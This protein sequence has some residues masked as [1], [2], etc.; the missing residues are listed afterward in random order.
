[1]C[2]YIYIYHYQNP[3]ITF[4]LTGETPEEGVIKKQRETV[5]A[6]T[7]EKKLKFLSFTGETE[8]GV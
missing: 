3:W 4:P 1:M 7:T 6:E 5:D 2:V 8:F